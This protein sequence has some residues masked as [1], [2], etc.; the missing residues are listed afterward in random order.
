MAPR[1]DSPAPGST[2]GGFV[3]EGEIGSGGMG[4]VL[5]GRQ[6]NLDRPAVLKKLRNDLTASGEYV[7][8][9]R[10]EARAAAAV[11]NQNVVAVFD[12]FVVRD[13]PSIALAYVDGVEG[14]NKRIETFRRHYSGPSGVSTECGMGRR[15]ADH[16]LTQL[17]Q[18][19]RDVVESL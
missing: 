18:I 5:A 7:E 12:C 6:I 11:H 10:R 19:H 1:K 17:L 8:R 4:V 14:T 16:S 2:I 15:P 3:I 9:F 13:D